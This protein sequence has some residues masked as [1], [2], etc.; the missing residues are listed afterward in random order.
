M[1]Q[2]S[3]ESCD[4]CIVG[5]GIV[6]LTAA[7]LLA[8]ND[9]SVAVIEKGPATLQTYAADRPYDL[10]V[11]AIN[12]ASMKIFEHLNITDKLLY[13]RANAYRSMQ[14]WDANSDASIEFDAESIGLESLGFII[15]NNIIIN[16]LIESLKAHNNVIIHANNSLESIATQAGSINITLQNTQLQTS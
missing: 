11:S 8:K 1:T 7:A 9:L 4:I 16:A 13:E 5:G 10:R 6:G 14:I 12:P 2:P 3:I 15:E